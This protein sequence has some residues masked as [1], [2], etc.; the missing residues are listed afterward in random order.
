VLNPKIKTLAPVR[1]WEFRSRDEEIA[2]AKEHK[3]PIDV[4]KKSPY[5]ID[6][7]LWGISIECGVLEDPFVEP[8]EDAFQM[9]TKVLGT[10]KPR[11]IEITFEKGIPVA[12]DGVRREPV[13][14]IMK[15]NELAGA[16][17]IGR[18]DMVE[19]RLVGIKSREVYEA[20]AAMVLV[21]AHKDLEALTLDR[22]TTHFKEMVALKYADLIYYGLWYTPLKK[23]LDSFID[24]TQKKVSGVIRM[25][26]EP[27]NCITVGRK[28][29]ESLYKE[30]LATYTEKDTFDQKLAKGFIE[31]WAMPYK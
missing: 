15:L 11:Y 12:L 26:L 23:A 30:E 17:G 25:K 13:T 29:K 18:S 19:N 31:I 3:I 14:L 1:E 6:K 21:T 20:P 8:P 4:T 10:K 7:N 24:A 22:E 28:S 16:Y 27:G 9:T 2:Y 5:S